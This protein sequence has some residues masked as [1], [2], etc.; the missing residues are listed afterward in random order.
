MGKYYISFYLHFS[1]Y[2]QL[3]SYRVNILD[4]TIMLMV[5]DSAQQK[6][7]C[8]WLTASSSDRW[9]SIYPIVTNKITME[10]ISKGEQYYQLHLPFQ[11]SSFKF[12]WIRHINIMLILPH[13]IEIWHCVVL[14]R[15]TGPTAGGVHMM[16]WRWG[17]SGSGACT[18]YTQVIWAERISSFFPK[19]V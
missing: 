17:G 15:I 12:W 8:N 19:T 13:F 1:H 14:F 2:I 3:I 6:T 9:K 7:S 10:T 5:D 4:H 16:N 11:Q 18:S